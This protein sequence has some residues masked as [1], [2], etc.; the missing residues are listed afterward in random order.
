M[1]ISE[2]IP[3]I[4]SL[5]ES[6]R[7]SKLFEQ[8]LCL[9]FLSTQSQ[10]EFYLFFQT[11]YQINSKS[12]FDFMDKRPEIKKSFL[13]HGSIIFFN[14]LINNL[15][16]FDFENLFIHTFNIPPYPYETAEISLSKYV[17]SYSKIVQPLNLDYHEIF[18]RK[19][20]KHIQKM[21]SKSLSFPTS[22]I[23]IC[24]VLSDPPLEDCISFYKFILILP[25]L[26]NISLELTL[27]IVRFLQK[28]PYVPKLFDKYFPSFLDSIFI[29]FQN[30]KIPV[31]MI[32]FFNFWICTENII[33]YEHN[34]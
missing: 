27:E 32:L 17:N 1:T 28:I 33:N 6:N 4:S 12:F 5:Q 3:S 31:K 16:S 7:A 20:M 25:S 30:T 8:Y 18:L 15:H 29:S 2:L 26:H 11:F 13:Q 23:R 22:L 10:S 34:S 19:L 14:I 21:K 24:F 9:F